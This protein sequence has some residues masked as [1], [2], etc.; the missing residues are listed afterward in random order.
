MS[1]FYSQ[2]SGFKLKAN[3]ISCFLF[4]Y[5]QAKTDTISQW[6]R[7][8]HDVPAP[9]HDSNPTPPSSKTQNSFSLGLRNPQLTIRPYVWATSPPGSTFNSRHI[10]TNKVVSSF[11]SLLTNTPYGGLLADDMGLVKTIQ[12]IVLIGT[13]K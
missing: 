11:E 13:F 6:I 4:I 7:P 3:L 5:F 9:F 8:S 1:A 10:I 2:I 12:A